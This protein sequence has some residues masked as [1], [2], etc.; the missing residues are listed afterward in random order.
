MG[1][2]FQ[3]RVVKDK[4][5]QKWYDQLVDNAAWECGHGGYTGSFAEASGT[6]GFPA[7]GTF[8]NLRA[9]E[10]WLDDHAQKWEAGL[11]VPF[12]T[13]TDGIHWAIG[14]VCSS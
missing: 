7:A 8:P 13:D 2:C 5:D 12:K 1:A 11:A 14:A 10:L 4:P 6:L 9:A 3:M